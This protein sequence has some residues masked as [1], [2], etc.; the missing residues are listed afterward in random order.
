M[1]AMGRSG[2]LAKGVPF[3]PLNLFSPPPVGN[4]GSLE[5]RGFDEKVLGP[6]P[7]NMLRK[8]PLCLPFC[9]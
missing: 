8:T 6:L 7:Q 3:T 9:S 1:Q 4:K 5:G 2:D